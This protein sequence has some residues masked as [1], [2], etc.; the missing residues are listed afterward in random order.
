MSPYFSPYSQVNARHIIF[1]VFPLCLLISYKL[2]YLT[3]FRFRKLVLFMFIFS[4]LTPLSHIIVSN[5]QYN[6]LYRTT[7]LTEYVEN[8]EKEG[9]IILFDQHLYSVIFNHHYKG[10]N[11]IKTFFPIEKDENFIVLNNGS[12]DSTETRFMIHTNLLNKDN[13]QEL[14]K[15]V[16]GSKRVW[17][18]RVTENQ[19]FI[20]YFIENGWVLKDISMLKNTFPV[21]LFELD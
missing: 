12:L 16:E 17:L 1:S 15:V 14:S 8:N 21:Y 3:I 7:E 5:S 18:V 20:K 10:L 11:E 19:Y 13:Y 4:F 6:C 2:T 9:D